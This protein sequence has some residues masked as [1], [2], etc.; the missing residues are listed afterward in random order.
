MTPRVDTACFILV[1][2]LVSCSR[3]APPTLETSTRDSGIPSPAGDTDPKGDVSDPIDA[4]PALGVA[5]RQVTI[6]ASGDVMIHRKVLDSAEATGNGFQDVFAALGDAITALQHSEGGLVTLL[7][8]ETPLTEEYNPP[9]NAETPVLGAPASLAKT[10]RSL[11]IDVVSFAN[12]HAF[13]QTAAGLIDSLRTAREAG[14][15]TVGAGGTRESVLEPWITTRGG[16][17]IGYLGAAGHVNG[18]PGRHGRIQAHVARLRQENSLLEAIRQLRRRVDLVVIAVHWSHDF[19]R[20]PHRSQRSLAR[21]LVEA[22]ADIILGTGPHVL[23]AVEGLPSSRGGAIVAYSLG[24]VI[25]NQGLRYT[26]GHRIRDH[27]HPVAITPGTR[28]VVLLTIRA[29]VPEPGR[30]ELDQARAIAFWNHNNFWERRG[31]DD[32]AVDIRLR[33]LRDVDEALRIERLASIRRA[34]GED[35]EVLP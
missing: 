13:D 16:L 26:T 21:R 29:R 1:A 32:V 34:L 23:Q 25:S 22:G 20:H 31:R 19:V 11:G 8:Q 7:N 12:N 30:L 9:L 3:S 33:R 28:D 6:A 27:E 15:G 14:L 2:I 35:V 5:S 17:R 24:N 10:L 18:A 4:G